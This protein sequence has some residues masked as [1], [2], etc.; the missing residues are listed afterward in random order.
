MKDVNTMTVDRFLKLFIIA[1]LVVDL[2][3]TVQL[4]YILLS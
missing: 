4:V 3:A 1:L 2:I